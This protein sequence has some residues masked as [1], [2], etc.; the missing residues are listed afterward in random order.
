[1]LKSRKPISNKKSNEMCYTLLDIKR[2]MRSHPFTEQERIEMAHDLLD[3]IA[4]L[5]AKT[6]ENGSE[7]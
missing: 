3:L 7:K 5:E 4:V 2:F 6:K 1:L